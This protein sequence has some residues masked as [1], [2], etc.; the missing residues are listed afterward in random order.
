MLSDGL[1]LIATLL[2]ALNLAK[3]AEDA[4]DLI[5]V[6]VSPLQSDFSK[7]FLI[8]R[9]TGYAGAQCQQGKFQF[10]FLILHLEINECLG[11]PRPCSPVSTCTNTPG[12]YTCAPCPVGYNG[13][14]GA[15]SLC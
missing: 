7:K 1:E 12:N 11:T 13:T 2:N 10:L 5:T 3:M 9:G 15:T 6:I 4:L 8:G 14:N